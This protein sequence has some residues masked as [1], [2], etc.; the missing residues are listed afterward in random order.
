MAEAVSDRCEIR[1]VLAESYEK[2]PKCD[3]LYRHGCLETND[4]TTCSMAVKYCY[5]ILAIPWGINPSVLPESCTGL[6]DFI[7]VRYQ[8]DLHHCTVL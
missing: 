4:Y 7:Q 3:R 5:D 2:V 6:A 8:Q 1:S